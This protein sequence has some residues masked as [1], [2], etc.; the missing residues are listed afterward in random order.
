MRPKKNNSPLESVSWTE[1]GTGGPIPGWR[2][3]DDPRD[4]RNGK[5]YKCHAITEFFL[6]A[7]LALGTD[8]VKCVVCHSRSRRSANT[9]V[10]LMPL[11]WTGR[12]MV[13]RNRADAESKRQLRC[14][15]DW[16]GSAT[17]SFFAL[18]WDG[19]LLT[20]LILISLTFLN[21][22]LWFSQHWHQ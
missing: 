10:F 8:P 18:R 5:L 17:P 9:L 1:G 3:P 14:V 13:V 2:L 16:A 6:T 4:G 20:Q 21:V 12:D 7:V 11:R 15:P 22:I 19:A